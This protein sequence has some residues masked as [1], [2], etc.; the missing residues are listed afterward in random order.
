M[1]IIWYDTKKD[2][3]NQKVM[4]G[5]MFTLEKEYETLTRALEQNQVG[6]KELE[7]FLE[8][9]EEKGKGKNYRSFN[10]IVEAYLYAYFVNAD[11]YEYTS[12]NM[13]HLYQKLASLY[14]A[15]KQNEKAIKAYQKALEWNGA[16]VEVLFGLIATYEHQGRWKEVAQYAMMSHPYLCTRADLAHF[17]RSI[18]RYY[19]ETYQPETAQVIYRYSQ[20][21]Y[22]TKQAENEICYI[23]EALK[24]KRP[25][26]SIQ[27]M[28]RVLRKEEV[29]EGPNDIT[30][31]IIYKVAECEHLAGRLDKAIECYRLVYDLTGDKEVES[32]LHELT[33]TQN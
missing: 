28:Q 12:V 23:E 30:V 17:Y 15:E 4:E 18:G 1:V 24:K 33:L 31:A 11:D 10:H 6:I 25:E 22:E 9:A 8:K 16:D 14:E 5:D 2:D 26:C 32:I 7:A 3:I 27:E 29:P 21:F 20:F 19:L 13:A